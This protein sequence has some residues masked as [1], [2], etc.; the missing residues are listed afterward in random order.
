MKDE[1]AKLVYST[2]GIAPWLWLPFCAV[3]LAAFLPR[4]PVR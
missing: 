2:D 1:R 4:Y 3:A